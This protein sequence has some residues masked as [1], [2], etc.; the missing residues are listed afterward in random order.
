MVVTVGATGGIGVPATSGTA[1]R[2]G[3]KRPSGHSPVDGRLISWGG[4]PLWM[5]AR[6]L[7]FSNE[8]GCPEE[9]GRAFHPG[10]YP[11]SL[12]IAYTFPFCEVC[13]LG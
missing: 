13:P 12:P 8:V 7:P 5:K 6:N 10:G 1:N 2:S 3:S 9:G 11:F 4:G